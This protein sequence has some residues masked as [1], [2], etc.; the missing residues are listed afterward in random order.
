M[1]F[2]HISEDKMNSRELDDLLALLDTT[3]LTEAAYLRNVTQPAFSRRI[4]AIEQS[5]GFDIIDR[6]RRPAKLKPFVIARHQEFRSLALSLGR[7]VSDLRSSS[8]TGSEQL[9]TICAIHSI[10]V[11]ELPNAIQKMEKSLPH[12]TVR[13]RTGNLVECYA[14]MMRDQV[15]IMISYNTQ[16]QELPVN[17][18]LIEQMDLKTDQF[19]PVVSKLH[20]K[21]YKMK[22]SVNEKVPLLRYPLDSFL[23][24]AQEALLATHDVKFSVRAISNLSPSIME[25]TLCGLGIG[26]VTEAHATVH[27]KSGQLVSLADILPCTK[28]QMTMMRAIRTREPFFESAWSALA[29]ALA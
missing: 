5:L 17:D 25:M 9:L 22:L 7:L 28:L 13:L 6:S 16:S 19:I 11:A 23:G 1:Q 12:L 21:D 15:E 24:T 18:T 2:L 29:L 14:M 8:F 4:R 3:S 20:A 26:W 27:I 10:A